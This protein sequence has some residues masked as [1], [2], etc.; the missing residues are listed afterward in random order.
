MVLAMV[1]GLACGG[2]VKPPQPSDPDEAIRRL[3]TPGKIRVAQSYYQNGR[4]AR[5]IE[6][7]EDAIEADPAS[8]A[9][10]NYM[11]QLL[12]LMGRYEEAEAALRGALEQDPYMTD[13]HNNLGAVYAGLDDYNRAEKEFLTVLE[14][15]TYPTPEKAYLNLGLLY[16]S[17]GRREEAIRML[18]RAVEV[19]TDFHTGHYELAGILEKEGKLREAAELY[20]VAAPAYRQSAVYHLR[21]GLTYFRLDDPVRAREHFSRVRELS[22]GSEAAAQA[23][24]YLALLD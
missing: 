18:R 6:I 21:L 24:E 22:P 5:A 17:Q 9:A 10:R 23:A 15:R 13:A 16:E 7:M 3:D 19:N 1:T 14:D 2:G 12:L 4:A 20:E 8:A 11:G